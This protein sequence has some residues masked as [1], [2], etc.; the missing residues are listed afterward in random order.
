MSKTK[1]NIKKHP[2]I[3]GHFST[4]KTHLRY[5]YE[6]KKHDDDNKQNQEKTNMFVREYK[7]IKKINKICNS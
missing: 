1:K 4:M 7:L 2:N 6:E 5:I 3:N